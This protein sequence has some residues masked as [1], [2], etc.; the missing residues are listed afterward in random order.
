MPVMSHR[1]Q[2]RCGALQ[3]EISLPEQ[4]MRAVCYCGDCQ[5]YAHLLGE[6]Q[7][8]LDALG[9]TDVVATQARHVT[10][11]SSTQAL[12]C[13]SLSPRGLL[14]WYAACCNTPIANTPRS[15]KL[16]YVGLVHTCLGQP[17]PIER[18]F[19]TVQMRVHRKGAKGPPPRGGTLGGM[20]QFGGLALRL[21]ASRLFGGY[22]RTPF[23]D[24]NGVPRADV[25]VAQRTEVEAARRAV[26]G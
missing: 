2:C 25:R 13:V 23:F 26:A 20:V 3:G 4:A 9:G 21:T 24:S 5:A 16:P 8:V 10:F 22:S 12:A 14:R 7:R 18:S 19:P 15:W 6:P 1:F 17:A 11:T